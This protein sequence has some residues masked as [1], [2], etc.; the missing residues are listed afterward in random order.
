VRL[1]EKQSPYTAISSK[2]HFQHYYIDPLCFWQGN[3]DRTLLSQT[4]ALVK[5]E[6][7][8]GNK[9]SLVNAGSHNYAG[10][11]RATSDS[12]QLQRLCLEKLPFS[13]INAVPSLAEAMNEA[14][15]QHF[16]VDFCCTT[17]TGFGSNL[18][19]MPAIVD[20]SWLV[21]MD[22]KSHS[23][24]HTGSFLAETGCRKKFRHNDMVQLESI[25]EELSTQYKNILVAVEGFYR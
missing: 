11:Y 23:S 17:S 8:Y 16:R 1:A 24:M 12:E 13:D 5:V 20:K 15:C 18:L 21:L 19:A 14:V 7:R 10:F 3:N 25:L 6:D 4:L 2:G 22:E 9:Q